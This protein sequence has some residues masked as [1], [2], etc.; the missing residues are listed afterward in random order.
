MDI[1][2]RPGPLRS[3]TLE[4]GDDVTPL[5]SVRRWAGGELADLV[6]DDLDDCVLVVTELVANAYDHGHAPRRVRL[7]R[8]SEPCVVRI[9]VD[10]VSSERPTL[11]RSRLGPHRGR[12]LVLV[13]NLS[14]D[15]G[16]DHHP[17]GKTVWAEIPCA[18]AAR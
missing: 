16:V 6:D 13:A 9:E 18:L 12:G 10:D 4:L 2:D 14:E 17:H 11:G 15:W 1:D 7:R 3:P 5:V 8:S